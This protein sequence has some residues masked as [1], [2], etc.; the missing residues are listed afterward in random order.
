MT[1]ILVIIDN[2]LGRSLANF[3]WHLFAN[4]FWHIMAF[5]IW[6][7]LFNICANLLGHLGTSC[8]GGHHLYL[9]ARGFPERPCTLGHAVRLD[10]TLADLEKMSIINSFYE[11]RHA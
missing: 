7:A 11:V 1:Q 9:V 2:A 8:M 3:T 4:F 5:L 10:A 6:H